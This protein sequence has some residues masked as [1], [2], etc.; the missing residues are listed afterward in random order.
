MSLIKHVAAIVAMVLFG[1]LAI[2][3]AYAGDHFVADETALN[4]A[5]TDTDAEINITVTANITLTTSKVVPSGKTVNLSSNGAGANRKILLRD[6]SMIEAGYGSTK[7]QLFRVMRYGDTL[8]LSN[9]ILDGA[10]IDA[11]SELILNRGRVTLGSG[12]TLRNNRNM[13]GDITVSDGR[14]TGGGIT[15]LPVLSGTT[16]GD[17]TLT[18]LDG[19]EITN[20]VAALGCGV[21]LFSGANSGLPATHRAIVT[22]EGGKIHGN[23]AFY[24]AGVYVVQN[25]TFNLE[26]GE[27]FDN[28]ADMAKGDFSN[29]YSIDWEDLFR[30]SEPYADFIGNASN[31]AGGVFTTG[32]YSD[33]YMSGGKIYNNTATASD[34]AIQGRSGGIEASS[35]GRHFQITGGEIY[36][37]TASHL[38]GGI[39]TFRPVTISGDTQIYGNKAI[40]GRAGGIYLA[41]ASVTATISDN[42]QIKNNTAATDGGGIYAASGAPVTLSDQVQITHNTAGADGGGIWAAYASLANVNVGADVIFANNRAQAAYLIADA[43][44]ATH[45]THVATTHFTQPFDQPAINWGYNNYDIAYTA[46][47]L[48]YVVSFDSR[49]GSAVASELIAPGDA[50]TRP[51]DPTRPNHTFQGWYVDSGYSATYDFS[52]VVNSDRTLYARWQPSASTTTAI[53]T[54]SSSALIA[55]GVLLAGLGIGA[56]RRCKA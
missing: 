9:I 56:L 49:G 45:A 41:S 31:L 44:K 17:A 22:M 28:H 11:K 3:P 21:V 40:Q 47:T 26:G 32:V 24:A 42:V 27:I 48:N 38:G 35:Y 46:G 51:T 52:T 8:N 12:A 23:R 1:S 39:L 13:T 7:S 15:V 54:T 18:I 5:L 25:A 14:S 53:P 33:F 34:A 30:G 4:N 10:N 43:D 29:P 36:G 50:A 16:V 19:A 2:A 55:L 6:A 20:N 37:N